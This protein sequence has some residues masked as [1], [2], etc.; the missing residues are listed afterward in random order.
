MRCIYGVVRYKLHYF[1]GFV[2]E[3]NVGISTVCKVRNF[4]IAFNGITASVKFVGERFGFAHYRTCTRAVV[5][6]VGSVVFELFD[7][8]LD[9]YGS[10]SAVRPDRIGSQ[11]ERNGV[12]SRVLCGIGKKSAHNIV[13]LRL[14]FRSRRSNC[15]GI[16]SIPEVILNIFFVV[17]ALSGSNRAGH[18]PVRSVFPETADFQRPVGVIIG[19][20]FGKSHYAVRRRG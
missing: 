13:I 17:E 19:Y 10:I 6:N 1:T 11:R 18:P 16:C 8:E 3:H 5:D 12:R 20:G 9:I 14:L 2:V 4:N 7:Y 15:T